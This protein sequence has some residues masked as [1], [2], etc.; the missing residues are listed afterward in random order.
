M[1]PLPLLKRMDGGYSIAISKNSI[2]DKDLRIWGAGCSSGE[3][4]YTLA[5]IIDDKNSVIIDRIKKKVIFRR[6]K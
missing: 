6:F 3:E 1:F 5:M 2:T 4:P